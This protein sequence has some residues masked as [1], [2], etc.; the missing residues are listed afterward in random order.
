MDMGIGTQAVFVLDRGLVMFHNR[1]MKLVRLEGLFFHGDR[2]IA[3]CS[4]LYI[5]KAL[6]SLCHFRGKRKNAAHFK[7]MAIEV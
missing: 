6:K 3:L 7:Y 1:P 2:R 5:A 4:H